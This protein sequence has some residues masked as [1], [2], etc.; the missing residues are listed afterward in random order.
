MADAS[1]GPAV[2]VVRL[3]FRSWEHR[4]LTSNPEAASVAAARRLLPESATA[5]IY[6]I[7]RRWERELLRE[8]LPFSPY[9]LRLRPVS[10][11]SANAIGGDDRFEAMARLSYSLGEVC[12]DWD[13]VRPQPLEK[14]S[15]YGEVLR[16]P[17]RDT[18]IRDAYSLE[19]RTAVFPDVVKIDDLLGHFS[20][21]YETKSVFPFLNG[22]AT[23]NSE[24]EF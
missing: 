10:R 20:H 1:G 23:R 21:R 7:L 14:R 16:A 17:T 8:T 9:G 11:A 15:K 4:W 2:E 24:S 18:P 3:V 22:V 12:P 5:P 6:D 13:A 19:L